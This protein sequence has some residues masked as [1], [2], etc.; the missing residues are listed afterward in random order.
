MS[1]E[2]KIFKGTS[3]LALFKSASQVISWGVTIIVARILVPGDFGLMDMATIITGYAFFF[4]EL[5][6]GAAIIQRTSCL[7]SSGLV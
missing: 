4:S 1:I 2:S 7:P 6:F 5:G 3:W